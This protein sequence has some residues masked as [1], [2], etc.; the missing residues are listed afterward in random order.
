MEFSGELVPKN[1]PERQFYF[2]DRARE[3][4]SEKSMRLGRRLTFHVTTFGCQMN[5]KDSEKIRGILDEIGYEEKDDEDADFVLMNTCTVRENA[6]NKVYGRLGYLHG[7]KKKN[8][9]M[10]I[11]ICGCMMQ[12]KEPVERIKN[13]Y[14]FVDIIF[15]THNI[16]KLAELLVESFE[17]E[18]MVTDIWDGTDKIVERLPARRKYPFK[19]GVNIMYGCNNFCSYCIVPYVRGRERSRQPGE[20][21]EEVRALAGDGV[22]EVMLLGQNVNSYGRTLETPCSFSKLLAEVAEVDGIERVRF[23]TSHPKDLSDDLIEVMAKY[24]NVCDHLHLPLQSGSSRLLG[25]MNRH[26]TKEGYLQL[27]DKLKDKIPEISLTTDIIVGFPGET[28]ED[29]SDTLDVVRRVRYDSAFTFIYSKRTGTPAASFEDQIPQEIIKKRF[30][31]LLNEVQ[32]IAADRA[33]RLEGRVLPVLFEDKN[34]QDEGMVTG[35]LSNNS[36]VHVKGDGSLIG[37][38]RD[39]R[40]VEAKGFYYIG[41]VFDK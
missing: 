19:S 32:G 26:Y 25:I 6:N 41:E 2:I 22:R 24:E 4:V 21:L 30:D 8:P 10:I 37:T 17:T 15:G 5:A 31:R 35:R 18:A 39:V 11:A 13:S 33:G 27:V 20:I 36:L 34:R 29:F 3:I 12:E 23:M 40:L 1:E 38:I 14:G 28:E 9:G 16:F 7:Y